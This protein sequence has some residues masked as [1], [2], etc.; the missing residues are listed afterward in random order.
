MLSATMRGIINHKSSQVLSYAAV[1]H[2]RLPKLT[3]SCQNFEELLIYL[4]SGTP[5]IIPAIPHG[6]PPATLVLLHS[7]FRGHNS[8]VM[9]VVLFASRPPQR[10]RGRRIPVKRKA[11]KE[12]GV[13]PVNHGGPTMSVIIERLEDEGVNRYT[14]DCMEGAALFED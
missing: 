13:H 11:L 12:E 14:D 9:S 4:S 1:N 3:L 10:V 6:F 8:P 2:R 7:S 5:Q